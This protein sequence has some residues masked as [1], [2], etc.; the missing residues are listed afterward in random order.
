MSYLP[1]SVAFEADFEEVRVLRRPDGTPMESRFRWRIYRDRR[2]RTRFELPAEGSGLLVDP[3]T[4]RVA[5]LDLASGE[6]IHHAA[7]EAARA[8]VKPPPHVPGAANWPRWPQ[9]GPPLVVELEPVVVDGI[10][11]RG[12]RLTFRDGVVETWQSAELPDP[13]ILTRC[14]TGTEEYEA[15]LFNIRLGETDP[16]LFAALDPPS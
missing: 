13:A 15:R 4:G 6:A 10:V 12:R 9:E 11:G 5:L 16:G 1:P 7:P 14:R 2:G 3:G 8:P